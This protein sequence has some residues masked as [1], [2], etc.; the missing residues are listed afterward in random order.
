MRCNLATFRRGRMWR[1]DNTRR[2]LAPRPALDEFFKCRPI[3]EFGTEPRH[4]NAP[5]GMGHAWQSGEAGRLPATLLT[6]F[7]RAPY[8]PCV[9]SS[10]YRSCCWESAL[11]RAGWRVWSRGGQPLPRARNGFAP[12]MAGSGPTPGTWCLSSAREF[13]RSWWPPDRGSSP[14][15]PSWRFTVRQNRKA[16]DASGII[17]SNQ[18]LHGD[19]T[20]VRKLRKR[21]GL[22][23][24]SHSKAIFLHG[25]RGRFALLMFR[26]PI[27]RQRVP[28]LTC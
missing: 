5:A 6:A 3:K 9:S 1:F 14:C 4:A 28:L 22:R 21:F 20:V 10:A 8:P 17:E 25:F 24:D 15:S 27:E 23:R 19:P 16:A 18:A 11:C 26:M 2:P 7:P 13:I 12:R